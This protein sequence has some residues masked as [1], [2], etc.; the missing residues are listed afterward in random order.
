MH[1]QVL[2]TLLD[3]YEPWDL[4]EARMYLATKEFV[5]AQP[6]CFERS[7]AEGHVTG[8]AWIVSPDRTQVLLMHHRKLDRWFQPGGH[9]DGDSDVRRVALKE[10][11]EETGVQNPRVVGDGIFDVDVHLIPANAK[12]A[13]HYHYDIRFLLEVDPKVPVVQNPEAKEV[14]WVPLA[15]VARYNDSESILRMARKLHPTA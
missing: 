7:L 9:C 5:R 11:E 3:R 8:S 15:E 10:A 13:A 6:R 14:R 2:L 1:R 12:E 4:N